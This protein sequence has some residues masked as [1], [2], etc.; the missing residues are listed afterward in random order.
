M[1]DSTSQVV[2]TSESNS[3]AKGQHEFHLHAIGFEPK[4]IFLG[5]EV[6]EWAIPVSLCP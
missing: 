6:L 5:P 2:G 3:M 4:I 1:V